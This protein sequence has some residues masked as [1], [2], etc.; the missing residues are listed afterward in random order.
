[1]PNLPIL[2]Q[3]QFL[4]QQFASGK[5]KG[6]TGLLDMAHCLGWTELMQA[7]ADGDAERVAHLLSQGSAS[8]NINQANAYGGTALHCACRSGSTDVVLH[9]LR[10]GAAVDPTSAYPS[11]LMV[12]AN[13]G[14]VDVVRVLL[15]HGANADR[16]TEVGWTAAMFACT[17]HQPQ[18]LEVLLPAMRRG[19]SSTTASGDTAATIAAA[20][21]SRACMR[22]LP[23]S[24]AH[25]IPGATS[26]HGDHGD[27]GDARV[28]RELSVME[29][30][31]TND[32]QALQA[33]IAR[34]ANVNTADHDGTTPLML[35][36]MRNDERAVHVLLKAGAD[37]DVQ[38]RANGWTALMQSVYYGHTQITTAL[39][40]AGANT[41][42][43]AM[44]GETAADVAASVANTHALHLI[45]RHHLAP[46]HTTTT[47]TS[48]TS[49]SFVS[50]AAGD[51]NTSPPT[52]RA[53]S[54][55]EPTTPT[56]EGQ[57]QH[58]QQQQQ[59]RPRAQSARKSQESLKGGL[60]RSQSFCI[61]VNALPVMA[62][63]N[64][65]QQSS[66]WWRRLLRLRARRTLKP[67]PSPPSSSS[68]P[69]SS[70]MPAATRDHVSS[71]GDGADETIAAVPTF[72]DLSASQHSPFD[73]FHQATPPNSTAPYTAA[74]QVAPPTPTPATSSPAP[75]HRAGT[76]VPLSPLQSVLLGAGLHRVVRVCQ[77][78]EIDDD[79]LVDMTAADFAECGLADGDGDGGD[80]G[81]G[82]D[83]DDDTVGRALA[84][85][86]QWHEQQQ[87][88][89]QQH[90]EVQESMQTGGG[91]GLDQSLLAFS[92]RF[93]ARHQDDDDDDDDNDDDDD[94]D[95]DDVMGLE[96]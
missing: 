56:T 2:F 38:S 46:R 44:S 79:T 8:S 31:L 11:P 63:K 23:S 36:A 35:A 59:Q 82:G 27:S 76:A 3:H 28:R 81:D 50:R 43:T 5:A 53:P 6:K 88:Q 96:S 68:P 57:Q 52:T 93:R 47:T 54:T 17:S 80:N 42:L 29:A 94:D 16:T 72:T 34:G 75:P 32:T 20:A 12:A 4:S 41:M 62:N 15:E 1:M 37:V 83:G 70:L 22:L 73:E 67:I 69:M 84:V 40:E 10:A 61:G 78:E 91:V 39:L 19:V 77:R 48:T 92:L 74:A 30:I 58:N 65:Q 66:P 86:V 55:K 95:D 60:R 14:R 45:H 24:P 71:A 51:N 33:A 13:Y 87:Q 9:L 26:A 25:R 49:P 90:E 64:K 18:A 7:A 21:N 89:Q 85:I